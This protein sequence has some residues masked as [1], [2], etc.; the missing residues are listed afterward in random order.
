MV[1]TADYDRLVNWISGL[2]DWELWSHVFWFTTEE[3][4]IFYAKKYDMNA[5]FNSFLFIN[6][7]LVA[8][9]VFAILLKTANW[10]I[11]LPY[12]YL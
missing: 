11:G 3:S 4:S 12:Y 5:L 9:I 7:F 1:Y 6:F 2:N 10:Q 8:N